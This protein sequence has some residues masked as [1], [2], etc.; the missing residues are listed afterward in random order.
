MAPRSQA[1]RIL[2]DLHVGLLRGVGRLSPAR[3][4]RKPEPVMA[5][6]VSPSSSNATLPVTRET[7]GRR[8]FGRAIAL[9]GL[10]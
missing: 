10:D 2:T 8:G 1:A 5:V 6:A 9:T 3:F 4:F 7:I